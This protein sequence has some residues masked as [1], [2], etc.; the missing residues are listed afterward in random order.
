MLRFELFILAF[1][2]A[3]N[4]LDLCD[5]L[6]FL[7]NVIVFCFQ[8][9]LESISLCCQMG[10]W[11]PEVLQ[12]G[13]SRVTAGS[14]SE[15]NNNEITSPT[16]GST[17]ARQIQPELLF[18]PLLQFS[19]FQHIFIWLVSSPGYLL[20]IHT[21]WQQ[22]QFSPRNQPRFL[23]YQAEN[24]LSK[25]NRIFLR[26]VHLLS[27]RVKLNYTQII[28]KQA[29]SS[30][31]FWWGTKNKCNYSIQRWIF[32]IYLSASRGKCLIPY[33][34]VYS[35][36]YWI[37]LVERW[38]LLEKCG[39]IF[40]LSYKTLVIRHTVKKFPGQLLPRFCNQILDDEIL[41]FRNFFTPYQLMMLH[42][43]HLHHV[44]ILDFFF[45]AQA[46]MQNTTFV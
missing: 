24:V 6:I 7:Q 18:H 3:S 11:A 37:V 35:V 19:M 39:D 15:A 44:A 29:S 31:N 20:M 26:R 13:L 43:C 46:K 33:W 1:V 16:W 21:V 14:G 30:A 22:L 41:G 23:F 4:L 36:R 34:P 42:V 2:A 17:A 8:V 28:I 45:F 10:D 32:S 12:L 25:E 38:P 27:V 40:S 5:G 9:L